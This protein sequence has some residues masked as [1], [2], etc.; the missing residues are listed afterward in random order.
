MKSGRQSVRVAALCIFHF[1]IA[2][3]SCLIASVDCTGTE[4]QLLYQEKEAF[5][6]FRKEV[7]QDLQVQCAKIQ[8]G[9]SALNGS[10]T[11]VQLVCSSWL[12][13][14][15]QEKL[16]LRQDCKGC[17]NLGN[18]AQH[19]CQEVCLSSMYLVVFQPLKCKTC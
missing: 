10:K 5:E 18:D 4:R 3:S 14:A 9:F 2:V 13:Q 1:F 7:L 6:M 11:A 16:R 19:T 17:S 15:E 12:L 8:V